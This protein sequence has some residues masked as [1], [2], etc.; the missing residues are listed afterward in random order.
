MNLE[1]R[2]TR[3]PKFELCGYFDDEEKKIV[4][5]KD[6]KWL[7]TLAHEYCHFLQYK[8]KNPFYKHYRDRDYIPTEVIEDWLRGK[9]PYSK[10]V[11]TAF[12]LVRNDEAECET[13]AVKIIKK[14]D[15][16][17]DM[18]KYKQLSNLY[19]IFYHCVEKTRKWNT[20]N[21]YKNRKLKSLVPLQ[22]RCLQYANNVPDK[23]LKVALDN[24]Q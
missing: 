6:R 13:W 10:R 23:I 2:N 17:I 5:Y 24:F 8:T 20:Y 21:F 9:I 19:L 15:L 18:A 4:I 12:S 22:L 7:C 14:Y 16:P 3:S 1:F 11:K